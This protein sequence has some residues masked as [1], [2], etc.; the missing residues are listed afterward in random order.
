MSLT[1]AGAG[2]TPLKAGRLS[3]RLSRS[4]RPVAGRSACVLLVAGVLLGC[5][6][7]EEELAYYQ[8]LELADSL[9]AAP[10]A[11]A[12]QQSER[13]DCSGGPLRLTGAGPH[14]VL[15]ATQSMAGFTGEYG[16]V[17]AFDNVLDRISV[18]WG[19]STVTLFGEQSREDELY[20]YSTL[21][22]AVHEPEAYTR[23]Q[24]P[25]YCFVQALDSLDGSSV[26]A[27]LTDGVQ[28]A[29]AF[30]NPSPTVRKLKEWLATGHALEII[31]FES[32]FSGRAWSEQQQGWVGWASVEDRPFYM[33]VFAH[34]QGELDEAI[35]NLS[36]ALLTSAERLRFPPQPLS[37]T[38]RVEAHTTYPPPAEA[39]YAFIGTQ[40][41]EQFF[42]TS[43]DTVALYSCQIAAGY[44]VA[45]LT[46][47]PS[48][49]YWR[50]NPAAEA[51][52]SAPTPTGADFRSDVQLSGNTGVAVTAVLPSTSFGAQSRFGF[53][54][55][56]LAPQSSALR[57][58]VSELSTES[59]ADV[60]E[61]SKTYRFDWLIEHL[62]RAHFARAVSPESLF[63]TVQQDPR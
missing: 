39:P 23:L 34:D 38:V 32:E 40:V 2:E 50:W 21:G 4:A 33:F 5:E 48:I 10:E 56:R 55:V 16:Q 46:V 51:F 47:Q 41:R 45:S 20:A 52:V 59:D 1:L 42:T 25:D 57:S 8:S 31:S 18:D 24:N 36:P 35:G 30:G 9:Q 19:V 15:D 61:F 11:Q 6:R 14:L 26:V 13:F 28:S 44:P 54:H 3:R 7:P 53:Y 43:P 12:A 63:L 29:S 17:T 60:G 27:Y 49:D 62:V 22:R 58:R 37:C